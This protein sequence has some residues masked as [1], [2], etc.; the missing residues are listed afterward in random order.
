M[1]A[2]IGEGTARRYQETVVP[3]PHAPWHVSVEVFT[4]AF[5][6]FGPRS[7][8]GRVTLA[9]RETPKSSGDRVEVIELAMRSFGSGTIDRFRAIVALVDEGTTLAFARLCELDAAVRDQVAQES[10]S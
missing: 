4:V 2:G 10:Q 3:V 5:D 1:S 9:E 7:I 8:W 6:G